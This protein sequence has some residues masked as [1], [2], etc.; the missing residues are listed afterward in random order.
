[1]K[2]CFLFRYGNRII[3]R[4]WSYTEDLALKQLALEHDIIIL[5]SDI[6]D[7][8]RLTSMDILLTIK[9]CAD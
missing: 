3:R 8:E 9:P 7:R 6:E 5:R 2:H 1:M 4:V